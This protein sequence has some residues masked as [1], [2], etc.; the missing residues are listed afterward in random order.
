MNNNQLELAQKPIKSLLLKYSVPAI[1]GMLVN[2]LYNVVDRIFIGNI[3]GVGSLAIAGLG[4]TMPI[5]TI[6]LAFGMLVGI[7]SA[8]NVSIKLGQNKKDEAQSIIGSG[9]VLSVVIGIIL[10]ILGLLF[11]N[12]I[13]NMFG[14]SDATLFY[15]K[16]YTRILLIGA[17]FAVM[18]MFFNN[19][20]RGDGNPKLSAIIMIVGCLTNVF[21]DAILIFKFNMGIE[22]AAIAT[23]SSQALTTIWGLSYYLRKKSN[24]EFK[25]ST[26]RLNLSTI[27]SIFAIGVS[28]FA[29]QLAASLVQVISNQSLKTY[30]GDLAIGA[31][32]TI[33]SIALL[34]LM[35]AFGISQGMQPIV[36]FN[37]GAGEHERVQKIFN[38]VLAM[39]GVIMVIGTILFMAAP[40]WL[41]GLY[42]E[43]ADTIA[44]GVTALRLIS[45]GFVFSA[46]S[47]TASGALEGLGKGTASLVISLCRYTVLIIPLA[48]VL[49]RILGPVGVWHAFWVTEVITAWVALVVYRCALRENGT[50]SARKMME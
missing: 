9:M 17:P 50:S 22:G 37:Y 1:I 41:M 5:A 15:A 33:S 11:C 20:I 6:I 28:P 35:P 46:M 23:I 49:S 27:K 12:Q 40:A 19:V 30:G 45:V 43:S 44:T 34:F 32:A 7:G 4:V 13:L 2:A 3:P 42:T 16:A 48:F 10:T 14:A 36:G 31:M 39:V 24:L 29:I 47:V 21:L 8:T 26:L 25:V 18:A 38:V